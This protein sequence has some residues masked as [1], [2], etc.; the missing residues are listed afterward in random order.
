MRDARPIAQEEVGQEGPREN[1]PNK[2]DRQGLAIVSWLFKKDSGVAVGAEGERV[3]EEGVDVD[4][5]RY[6]RSQKGTSGED[7]NK[8][9]GVT[10]WK[11]LAVG[12][13]SREERAFKAFHWL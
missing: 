6:R 9:T 5:D 2:S 11:V 7:L 8:E 13:A 3:A 12:S 1:R 4:I 10:R